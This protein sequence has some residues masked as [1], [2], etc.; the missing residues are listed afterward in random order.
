VGK[1][2]I[3]VGSGQKKKKTLCRLKTTDNAKGKKKGIM[4]LNFEGRGKNQIQKTQRKQEKQKGKNDSTRND[5][6]GKDEE[7]RKIF[8]NG[9]GL[10]NFFCFAKSVWG[11]GGTERKSR[12]EFLC[13]GRRPRKEEGGTTQGRGGGEP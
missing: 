5:L 3:A 4:K 12:D 10:G 11:G 1:I 7:E 2:F 6:R 9:E 13:N 8:R